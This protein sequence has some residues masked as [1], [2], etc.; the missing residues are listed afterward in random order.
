MIWRYPIYGFMYTYIHIYIYETDNH[1]YLMGYM[2]N[3]VWWE[4]MS[5]NQFFTG[6]IW[7]GMIWRP[8]D[9]LR[10]GYRDVPDGMMA[11]DAWSSEDSLFRHS[12]L[13]HPWNKEHMV[14]SLLY[15]S[16]LFERFLKYLKI[17]FWVGLPFSRIWMIESWWNVVDYGWLKPA[18]RM[19]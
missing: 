15:M 9:C 8:D 10:I 16:T 17:T 12:H 3:H 19:L 14:I 2:Y 1:F 7:L 11:M 18:C 4:R 6:N 5:F 13:N